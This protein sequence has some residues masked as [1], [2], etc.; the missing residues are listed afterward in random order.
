MYKAVV[1]DLDGT[2][3]DTIPDIAANL[4]RSLAERGFPTHPVERCKTFVG[5]GIINAIRRALPPEATE[6]DLWEVHAL[7]QRFYPENCTVHTQYYPGIRELLSALQEKGVALAILSNKTDGTAKRIAAHYFPD[8]TFR[9][10]RGRVPEYPLKPDPGAAAPILDVISLPP[11][12]IVYV[13]DSGTDM[14]FA[15]AVGMIPVAAPWGYRSREELVERGAAYVADDA[16]ALLQL[17]T[18]LK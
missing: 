11:E 5:D 8:I 18:D 15:K 17:L 14:T 3:L 2:L 9:C 10:V 6:D 1:F 4:N 7:Y 13:G 12:K 16:A